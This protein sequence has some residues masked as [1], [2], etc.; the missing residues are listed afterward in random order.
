MREA[1]FGDHPVTPEIADKLWD[2]I[3]PAV[4]H[5]LIELGISHRVT[6]TVTGN[7]HTATAVEK[8]DF[9][10]FV[11]K[12]LS[13]ARSRLRSVTTGAADAPPVAMGSIY[14]GTPEQDSDH[15][16]V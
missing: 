11:E 15:P 12:Q 8:A 10:R 2:F 3:N 5:S 4:D 6:A 14:K 1:I 9:Q 13:E 16:H 7:I